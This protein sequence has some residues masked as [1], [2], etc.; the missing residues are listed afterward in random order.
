[1]NNRFLLI[2]G[3]SILS[4]L[5]VE[6]LK[7]D[8]DYAKSTLQSSG[9]LHIRNMLEK[10]AKTTDKSKILSDT[11]QAFDD[12]DALYT[13]FAEPMIKKDSEF[14]KKMLAVKQNQKTAFETFGEIQNE[15]KSGLDKD[16]IR[17]NM[18][19]V[20]ARLL[21]KNAQHTEND[22][23]F[24]SQA[25]DLLREEINTKWS[26]KKTLRLSNYLVKDILYRYAKAILQKD[27]KL[28]QPEEE[29]AYSREKKLL[30]DE[31][32]KA[33]LENLFEGILSDYKNQKNLD[34][35]IKRM[36]EALNRFNKRFPEA[37]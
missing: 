8:D 22:I 14:A 29:R 24:L 19:K 25:T 36:H 4:G 2:L 21:D 1:M 18:Q 13:G 5:Q 20:I 31:K 23:L 16:G 6:N 7:A 35:S 17:Y 34:E 26:G 32:L 33:S 30:E 37:E 10:H 15:I 3:L 27:N 11:R 28:I 12:T 9:F